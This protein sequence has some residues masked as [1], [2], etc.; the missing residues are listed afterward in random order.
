MHVYFAGRSMHVVN[1]VSVGCFS[2]IAR[3]RCAYMKRRAFKSSV[4]TMKT[5]LLNSY[6]ARWLMV[7][8]VRIT[9]SGHNF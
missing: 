8:K 4:K 6:I 3:C 2:V 5:E 1:V 9:M 7:V